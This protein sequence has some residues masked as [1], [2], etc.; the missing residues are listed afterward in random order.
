[1]NSQLENMTLNDIGK[2]YEE[3]YSNIRFLFEID[4]LED[5][6]MILKELFQKDVLLQSTYF[7]KDFF[8][9]LIFKNY[10]NYRVPFLLLII[11]FVRYEYLDANNGSNFFLTFLENILNNQKAK[12][13][14]F[15]NQI[16]DYFFKWRGISTLEEEGLYIFS[17]QNKGVSLKLN[18]CGKHKYINSFLYH[19]GCICNND[20][21]KTYLRVIKILLEKID[22]EIEFVKKI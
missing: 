11:G 19:A 7:E 4:F 16:I 13:F 6:Y 22:I 20:D 17:L 2:A 8:L 1:M 10:P 12:V 9:F 18:N 5:D 15:R 3:R 14:D 21:L